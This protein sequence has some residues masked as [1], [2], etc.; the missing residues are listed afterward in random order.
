MAS[1][2]LFFKHNQTSETIY[3]QGVMSEFIQVVEQRQ[4]Q[5]G[6][7]LEQ[8]GITLVERNGIIPALNYSFVQDKTAFPIELSVHLTTLSLT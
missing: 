6:R 1:A 7:I 2:H 5:R 3:D 8:G 4:T